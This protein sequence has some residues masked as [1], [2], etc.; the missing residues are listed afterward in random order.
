LKIAQALLLRK[1][2]E[3]KVEQLK[4][5]KTMGDGGL[6]E[7]KVTRLNVTEQVDQITIN[8]PRVSLTEVTKEYDKYATALRKLDASVQKANWQYDV[9]FTDKENPFEEKKTK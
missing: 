1:Q 2:L 6:F 7:T 5:I 4:P 3:A 9:D 8:S